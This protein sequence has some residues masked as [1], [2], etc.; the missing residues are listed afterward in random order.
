MPSPIKL[1]YNM[2]MYRYENVQKGR[3]RQFHQCW[4]EVF[5]SKEPSID[6]EV[7]AFAMDVL[8]KLGL[9]KL[10]LHMNNLGCPTCRAKYNEDL[11]EYL[12]KNYDD[13]CDTCKSRFEKNPMRILDCK[14]K[15][16]RNKLKDGEKVKIFSDFSRGVS[17]YNTQ[18]LW[19][20]IYEQSRK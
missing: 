19:N 2:G 17:C 14:E 3:L 11:K 5:G 12:G 7:I 13:L 18:E 9:T 10:E 16:W 15:K 6:G 20:V 4:L 1:W 8:K